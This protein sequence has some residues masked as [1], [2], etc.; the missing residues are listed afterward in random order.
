MNPPINPALES[1]WSKGQKFLRVHYPVLGGAMTWVSN[2]E[3]VSAISN[4]GGFGVLA[5]GALSPEE[6]EDQIVK[7]KD[8]T[9]HSFGVNL[10]VFH[11]R[12]QELAEVCVKQKVS[13]VFLGGGMPSKELMSFFKQHHVQCVC[14]A[15]SVII[16]K[17]LIKDGAD[18]LIIEGTEAGGHVGP[19]STGVLVREILPLFATQLPIFVAGGIAEGGA[20]LNYLLMGAAGCQL[21][22]VFACSQESPAHQAFKEKLVKAQARDAV[23]SVQVDPKF[24]VIPVRSLKNAATEQFISFQ[25]EVIAEYEAGKLS[26]KEAQMKIEFFWSGSLRRAVLDGDIEKG[27]LMAGQSVGLVHGIFSCTEIIQRLAQEM[28]QS[29]SVIQGMFQHRKEWDKVS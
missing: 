11:P 25:K 18:A 8:R 28:D 14:F 2:Y 26:E 4:A 9:P 21:G 19:V 5:G 7:T 16:A 24:P 10:I 22:T 13:H 3:L 15:A 23:L 27:S 20:F 17:K 29:L 6:L 12:I 1:L